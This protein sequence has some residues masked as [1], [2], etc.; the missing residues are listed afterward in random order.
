MVLP[1]VRGTLRAG[2]GSQG[3]A[4]L[5]GGVLRFHPETVVSVWG[6]LRA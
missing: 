3:G 4:A 1:T 5:Q 6:W 2:Q